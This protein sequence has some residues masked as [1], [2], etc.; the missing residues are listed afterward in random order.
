MCATSWKFSTFSEHNEH[1]FFIW[2]HNV[3]E[4]F[5]KWRSL[6]FSLTTFH[7]YWVNVS[8]INLYDTKEWH[9]RM[10]GNEFTEARNLKS[11][12]CTPQH[13]LE[14]IEL[15]RSKWWE[16]GIKWYWIL[17]ANEIVKNCI[18]KRSSLT[19]ADDDADMH[20]KSSGQLCKFLFRLYAH[21]G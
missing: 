6:D 7:L 4:K 16:M 9:F 12:I 19:L 17:F 15:R 3:I 8:C 10:K 11:S 5:I 2:S 13:V 1:C 18:D 20:F 21:G 14:G